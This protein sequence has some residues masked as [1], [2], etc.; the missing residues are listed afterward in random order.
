MLLVLFAPSVSNN[1]YRP[2]FDE[3]VQFQINYAKSIMGNDNVVVVVNN[4]TYKYY[5]DSLPSDVLLKYNMYD[6]WARDFTTV[7]PSIPVEFT[8]TWASMTERE[9][10]QTQDQWNTFADRYDIQRVKSDYLLDGGNI[11]DNYHGKAITTSRFLTD[12]NLSYEQA[13]EELKSLLNCNQ[14]AIVEP[15]EDGLAHSDGMVMWMDSTHL[16]VNDYSAFPSYRDSVIDE[17]EYSFPNVNIIEM[18][19][20][21]EEGDNPDW[22]GFSSACGVH[23]NSVLTKHYIYVPQFGNEYDNAILDTLNKYS[24]KEIIPV[25]A[26]GVC[27]MGG[28]VRCLTWQLEGDNAIKLI[29][30][31]RTN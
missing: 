6:I 7:N 1:Y 12:N 22:E 16:L 20:Q 2:A 14:V 28:S 8:Y 13:K 10:R 26:D 31:A 27:A 9:S 30:A 25:Q 3:I 21:W 19:V 11:V 29:E 24:S 4:R 23:L 18:P 17:L 5:K 15:D